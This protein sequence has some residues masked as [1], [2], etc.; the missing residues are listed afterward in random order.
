VQAKKTDFAVLTQMPIAH[1]GLMRLLEAVRDS[2][3]DR[4]IQRDIQ[5]SRAADAR[6]ADLK[7]RLCLALNVLDTALVHEA[8]LLDSSAYKGRGDSSSS[9]R[10]RCCLF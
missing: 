4:V 9:G 2:L 1:L 3:M 10:R 6:D 7:S 8:V 5:L